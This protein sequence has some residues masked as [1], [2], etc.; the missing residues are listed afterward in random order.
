MLAIIGG[1]GLTSLSTLEVSHRQAL[2]TPWGE[3]SAA[4]SFGRMG[5]RPLVFLARHGDEHG[6]PPHFTCGR[7]RQGR[8]CILDIHETLVI[9]YNI[10]N[11]QFSYFIHKIFIFTTT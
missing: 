11:T 9:L 6:I 1:S 3:P 8:S 2:Q 5:G 4:L 7:L 10:E